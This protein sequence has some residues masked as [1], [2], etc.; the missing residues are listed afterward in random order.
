MSAA[1]D[2]Y[3]PRYVSRLGLGH[4]AGAALKLYGIDVD[5]RA[6]PADLVKEMHAVLADHSPGEG[7]LGFAILHRGEEAVWLLLHW[8]IEGGILA[9]RLWR[10]PLDGGETARFTSVD[11]PLMACVWEL[12]PIA[13]ER[14]AYVATLMNGGTQGDYLARTLAEGWY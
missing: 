1:P 8:W 7:R 5:G 2:R 12:V 14:D 6:L 13:F 3:R 4:P 11:R 10:R 9:E